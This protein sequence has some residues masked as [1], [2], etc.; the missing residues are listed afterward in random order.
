MSDY[1]ELNDADLNDIGRQMGERIASLNESK[2]AVDAAD[3]VVASATAKREEAAKG[4][5][6]KVD[7][8]RKEGLLTDVLLE[9]YGH[10]V[11]KRRGRK[12]A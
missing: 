12:S 9:K 10:P 1:T 7:E 5:R 8:I 11:P 6:A 4:Y 2:Q 3:E